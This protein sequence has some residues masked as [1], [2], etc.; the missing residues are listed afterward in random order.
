MKK[1]VFSVLCMAAMCAMAQTTVE[2]HIDR[3]TIYPKSALVEKSAVVNLKK[4]ENKVVIRGNA[5]HVSA[6]SLQF[7]SS[8]D[9]LISSSNMKTSNV[10]AAI[11]AS[12]LLSSTAYAQ[13][14]TLVKQRDDL[15]MKI[16]NND[17]LMQALQSQLAALS[18]LKAIAKT[19][20]IDTLERI[21]A[22]F[23]Y[24]RK[25]SQN[26]NSAIFKARKEN[27][28]YSY[29]RNQ[30]NDQINWLLETNTGGSQLPSE[31][32]DVVVS[33]TANR[34]VQNAM[35]KYSYMVENMSLCSYSYDVKLDEDRHRAIFCLKG[36]VGQNTGEHWRDCELVFSTTDASKNAFDRNLAPYYLDF[37]SEVGLFRFEDGSASN[38]MVKKMVRKEAAVAE[39]NIEEDAVM[40]APSTYSDLTLSRDFVLNTKQ[41]IASGA[42]SK[43]I[44]LAADTTIA[45]FA[46]YATPKN[47]EKV[48]YTALLPNWEDLG[49]LDAKCNVYLNDK[50]VSQSVIATNGMGDTM[51]FAVGEDRNVKVG[52][53]VQKSTPERGGLLSKDIE[54]LVTVTL[55]VKNTKAQ[56]L[57]LSM[58]DQIPI[59]KNVD[60]KVMNV[61]T[62]G[63]ELDEKSGI[64]R[65]QM[66]LAPRE[67]R[68]V[69]FSYI[70]RYPKGNR[71]NIE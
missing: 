30:L 50:Y 44:M 11:Q 60:I 59:S 69:T 17:Q 62:G 70:V 23:D 21:K 52:R 66:K 54:E 18:R 6:N 35:V 14:Q 24:Q 41:T 33:I 71:V 36:R 20:D 64:V 1:V 68:K 29:L 38:T 25:E 55:T 8:P 61:Q 7:A 49:L 19:Q 40:I 28:E 51:R 48:H 5:H 9:W 34:N 42:E 10:P 16:A 53:K 27:E 32:V 56:E 4:G 15:D 57:V 3:V 43:M 31:V 2:S 67:E 26:I 13:Y 47:E 22:Q 37:Y 46:H 63:G 12:R 58:K 45:E 39:R 65:W